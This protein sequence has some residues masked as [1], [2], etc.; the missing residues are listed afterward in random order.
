[1]KHAPC[2]WLLLLLGSISLPAAATAVHS[3]V[4]A[5]GVTHFS[6]APPAG[7]AVEVT[8]VELAEDFGP[9]TDPAADYYSIANQWKRMRDEREAKTKLSLEKARVRASESTAP[10]YIESAPEYATYPGYPVYTRAYPLY[11]PRYGYRHGYGR[12][13]LSHGRR[14]VFGRGAHHVTARG[15]H[16]PRHAGRLRGRS[17]SAVGSRGG[18]RR[19]Y[20]GGTGFSFGFGLH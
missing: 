6:D 12:P 8:T 20:R 16:I 13:G 3:W 9:A 4:D 10:A 11:S 2:R 14:G 1:M 17:H 5:D 18:Q 7:G 19:A 15:G